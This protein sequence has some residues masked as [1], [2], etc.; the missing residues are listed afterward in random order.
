[1]TNLLSSPQARLI[2]RA[3]L[4][5]LAAFAVALQTGGSLDWAG[6]KAAAVAGVWA[7]LEYATPL[8][9]LVGRK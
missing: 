8:N 9:A 2:G 6:V 7:L 1:L 3:I 4:A 5:G